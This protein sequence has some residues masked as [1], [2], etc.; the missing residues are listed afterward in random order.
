M[1]RAAALSLVEVIVAPLTNARHERFVAALL[2]GKDATSAYEAAGFK[3]DDANAARL[4]AN[5]KVRARLEE[6]QNEIADK[7]PITIESLIGELEQV[8]HAATGKNQ[9]AAAVRAILGK[10]QLGG[11]LVEKQ[12]VEVTGDYKGETTAEIVDEMLGRVVNWYHDVRP[13]DRDRIIAAHEQC[14]AQVR[15]IIEEIQSRP[16][17]TKPPKALPPPHAN[18]RS[19][20]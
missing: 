4:K 8:R 16:V 11:L 12:Q 5:P 7:V 17:I 6:M 14:H 15:A 13:E 1:S 19:R 3:R 20:Y 18:G 9:F 10:A 2:E